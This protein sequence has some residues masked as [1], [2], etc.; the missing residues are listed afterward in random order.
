MSSEITSLNN[1]LSVL[2]E[3]ETDVLAN[4]F[5]PQ[6]AY[7]KSRQLVSDSALVLPASVIVDEVVPV[8]VDGAEYEND[9]V[10]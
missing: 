6:N 3:Q 2:L 4:D 10:R 9:R 5:R 7:L 1:E 8:S